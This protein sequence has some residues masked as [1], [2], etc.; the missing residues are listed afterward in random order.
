[1]A[2][3]CV[4]TSC[5]THG[6]YGARRGDRIAHMPCGV[7][8]LFGTLVRAI[9]LPPGTIPAKKP[10]RQPKP[11]FTLVSGIESTLTSAR[12]KVERALAPKR[13]R[14]DPRRS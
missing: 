8:G 5:G 12:K 3:P 4:C 2:T 13:S 10:R 6:K 9:G 7:C 1:M 14:R 11:R